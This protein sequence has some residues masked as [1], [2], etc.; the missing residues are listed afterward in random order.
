MLA[1][2]AIAVVVG[3]VVDEHAAP[4]TIITNNLALINYTLGNDYLSD[5]CLPQSPSRTTILPALTLHW[6]RL[7]SRL[8]SFA[9]I[10]IL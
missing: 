9:N 1:V 7:D 10:S 2:A 4:G 3:F 8:R 5:K 6:T